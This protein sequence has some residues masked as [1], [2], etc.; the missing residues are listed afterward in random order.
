MTTTQKVIKYCALAF[1]IGIIV[2]IIVAILFGISQFSGILG[3]TKNTEIKNMEV[4]NSVKTEPTSLEIDLK[5]AGLELKT[6]S[7]FTI[8]TN[9]KNVKIQE[10]GRE[11][12]IKETSHNWMKA[13]NQ[14]TVQVTIPKDAIFTEVKIETGAGNIIIDNLTT[15]EFDLDIGAG[16]VEIKNLTVT[17][18]TEIDGGAGKVDILAGIINNLDLDMGVGKCTLT[19]I[20]TGTNKIDAGVGELNINLLDTKDNYRIQLEKGLGS[21]KL[22]QEEVQQNVVYGAGKSSIKVK[23]GIGAVHVTT[24]EATN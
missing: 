10:R 18:E 17:R 12:K 23:G 3:L 24:T 8:E 16:K 5:T 2:N 19:A 9:S 13:N 21:I 1:A 11:V 20:L 7:E 4:I 14:A 22:N 15:D 6:G